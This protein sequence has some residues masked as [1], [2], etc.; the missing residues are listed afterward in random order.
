MSTRKKPP[1]PAPQPPVPN[2][3]PDPPIVDLEDALGAAGIAGIAGTEGPLAPKHM[4]AP[5]QI[6]PRPLNVKRYVNRIQIVEAWQYRGT[7]RDA[8]DFIDRS[9]AAWDD[10]NAEGITPGPALRVPNG[11]DEPRL[12]RGGDYVVRQQITL[13]EG[14]TPDE[15]VEVWRREEFERLFMPSNREA[16]GPDSDLDPVPRQNPPIME[17]A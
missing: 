17:D 2:E 12:C 4:M 11:R 14:F 16:P 9:W 15:V 8:P 1:A 13:I 5:G 7:L 10:T 3:Q 6:P